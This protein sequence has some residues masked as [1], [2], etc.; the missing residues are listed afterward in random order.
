MQLINV[1]RTRNL[2][3][4]LAKILSCIGVLA[5]H[6]YLQRL[7][8]EPKFVPQN[9]IF[10]LGTL[11]IP[12]FF[13]T[14]GYLITRKA[15]H[16]SYYIRKIINLFKIVLSVNLVWQ[17]ILYIRGQEAFSIVKPV[18]ETIKNMY[19][20]TGAFALFWFFGALSIIYLFMP[21]LQEYIMKNKK[22]M[23][24]II[25][26]LL[27]IQLMVNIINIYCGYIGRNLLEESILQPFRLYNHLCYFMLGALLNFVEIS[28]NQ[29]CRSKDII[30]WVLIS[31]IVSAFVCNTIYKS[32]YV[33]Y[34]HCNIII[35]VTVFFV[36]KKLKDINLPPPFVI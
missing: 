33:E 1:N 15:H 35:T 20:Q 27:T 13:M 7:F 14:N 5:L 25:I 26:C 10:Y 2:G 6:V 9:T 8:V 36:F 29:L 18:V 3:I 22:R 17:V 32:Y 16:T 30:V 23:T 24:Y 28:N 31:A 19:F 12:L 4:D 21:L 11:A 34:L